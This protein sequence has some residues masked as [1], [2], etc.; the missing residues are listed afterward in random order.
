MNNAKHTIVGLITIAMIGSMSV[1]QACDMKAGIRLAALRSNKEEVSQII[2][3]D[4]DKS[5]YNSALERLQQTYTQ[6]EIN[7]ITSLKSTFRTSYV[8]LS[9]GVLDVFNA[10][11]DDSKII[12]CLKPCDCVQI[13]SSTEQW[14]RV[15]YQNNK[16]GYVKKE[17]I[18]DSKTEAEYAAMHYDNYKTGIIKAPDSKINVRRSASSSSAVLTMLDNNTEIVLLYDDNG[19]TK[20]YYGDDMEAGFVESSAIEISNNWIPKN[21]VTEIQTAAAKR[22]DALAKENIADYV[23]PNTNAKGP[24]IVN[25]AAKY[26]GT[27]YVY[28]GASPK[29]FDCSGL[30]QYVCKSL[31]ISISR[32]AASQF[33]H[34]KAVSKSDLEPGDLLF[35]AK[36]G[37]I[38]HVGIYAGDGKMIHAPR[39][40]DVVRYTSI[41]SQYRKN[42]Y[43][44][45]RRVY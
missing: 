1:K 28:G 42:G 45:A 21:K 38:N 26:L 40:G 36:N 35:F 24:D 8:V 43:I 12:D 17:F 2:A 11:S 30:V 22:K 9:Y 25:E 34:G 19:Y 31:G 29:G 3:E 13:I 15:I 14:Y 4:F 20:I 16:S 39:T 23:T 32:T 6:D 18:T 5:D 10:P 44:G 27:K 37:K 41:D 7:K 33:N